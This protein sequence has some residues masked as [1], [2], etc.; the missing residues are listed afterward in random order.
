MTPLNLVSRSL[1]ALLGVSEQAETEVMRHTPLHDTEELEA[2]LADAIA[3]IHRAADSLERHIAVL[4]SLADSLPQLTQ[5]VTHL[6][7]QLQDVMQITAPLTAA[8]RELSR[9][10]RLFGRRR[11]GQAAP[12]AGADDESPASGPSG[13]PTT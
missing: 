11:R 8:E 13:A 4:E 10:E 5:S 3:A 7:N 12:A 6:T 1:R 9:M 2:K